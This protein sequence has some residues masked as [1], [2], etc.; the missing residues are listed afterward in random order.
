MRCQQNGVACVWVAFGAVESRDHTVNRSA[1]DERAAVEGGLHLR[2]V[3]EL[4]QLVDDAA[5]H[6]FIRSAS[7]GVRRVVLE[8][9]VK[10]GERTDGGKLRQGSAGGLGRGR[11][12]AHHRGG[13]NNGPD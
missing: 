7:D 11:P 5:A 9:P 6:R 4:S 10:R 3:T 2:M 13:Q 12:E 1:V 8:Y